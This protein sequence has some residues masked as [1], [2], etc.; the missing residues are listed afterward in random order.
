M[1]RRLLPPALLFLSISILAGCASQ[2]SGYY[3]GG[4]G[5]SD[6]EFGDCALYGPGYGYYD[7]IVPSAPASS[8]RIPVALADR[9]PVPRVVGRGSSAGAATAV[10]RMTMPRSS[11][12]MHVSSAASHVSSSSHR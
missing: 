9:H 6:C 12:S 7:R 3:S 1:T 5:F 8:Q 2:S 10:S 11:F 4:G